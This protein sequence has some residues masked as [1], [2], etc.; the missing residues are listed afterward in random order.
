MEASGAKQ[1]GITHVVF[2]DNNANK[3]KV[4]GKIALK[5]AQMINPLIKFETTNDAVYALT[6]ADFIITTL[7]VGEDAGRV[8]DERVALGLGVLGQETTGAGGF[9]MAIRTV[10][11]LLEY[12]ALAQKIAKPQAPIFNFTN[13][14][15]I[16][17]QAL[18]D[19]G[20]KNV[21][22]ICD[23]PSGFT[24]Q[25]QHLYKVQDDEIS[26][27]CY[28]LN[29]L[30]WFDQVKIRG[31]DVMQNLVNNP[32][33]YNKTEMK[34]FDPKIV[35]L[36]NNLLL[37]EYLYFYYYR[38]KA[39]KA[40]LNSKQTRGESVLNINNTTL[41]KLL[42]IDIDNNMEEAFH[43]FMDAYLTRENSYMT[44]EAQTDR[45]IT[46]ETPTLQEFI[47]TPDDGGYAGVALRFI[48]AV[49]TGKK[50]EM[51]L[52]IPNGN[53][54]NGLL[55]SD[56][57]EISCSIDKNGAHPLHIGDI[58]D[59]QMNLIRTLKFYERNV[60]DAILNKNKDKAIIGLMSHPLVNSYPIAQQLVDEYLVQHRIEGW[61]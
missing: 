8:I 11:A 9:A 12:C 14:S 59:M 32:D 24:R 17:T 13:P 52:S 30:S 60:V 61:K 41:D 37:N 33:L 31:E 58:P 42:Q 15:G 53:A 49:A 2:M 50:T 38:E 55:P 3:L 51:V 18:H 43:I 34:L 16:V 27:R 47:A 29:H 48:N 10:P 21:Y 5:V 26:L 46:R 35:K 36:S 4:F 25:I 19:A 1:I 56:I 54:I 40:I 23:A 45:A 22:G 20:Y 57:V 44:L 39:L 6:D 7:R 28:G